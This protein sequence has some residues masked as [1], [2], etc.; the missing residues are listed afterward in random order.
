MPFRI[1]RHRTRLEDER[2]GGDKFNPHTGIRLKRRERP[3]RTGGAFEGTTGKG[4]SDE[5]GNR[6]KAPQPEPLGEP[7]FSVGMELRPSAGDRYL[8]S[9]SG[10]GG[11]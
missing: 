10:T 2:L 9:G 11:S 8:H 7:T 6:T 3:V 1:P 5:R 4:N